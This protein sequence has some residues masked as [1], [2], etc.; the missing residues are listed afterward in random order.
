MAKKAVRR[1]KNAFSSL[2]GAK[3]YDDLTIINVAEEAGV[4]RQ[5]FYYHYASME[6]F[7]FDVL[8]TSLDSAVYKDRRKGSDVVILF[9][10]I[11]TDFRNEKAQITNLYDSSLRDKFMDFT[12]RYMYEFIDRDI[13]SR[14]STDPRALSDEDRA[15]IICQYRNLFLRTM[16]EYIRSGMKEKPSDI[17]RGITKFLGRTMDEVIDSFL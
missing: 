13:D 15:F 10:A 12:G 11:L 2:L 16:E 1:F 4:T 9:T 3:N 8:K 7:V 6:E 14:L 17:G 5:S